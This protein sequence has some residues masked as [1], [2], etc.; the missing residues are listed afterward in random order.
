M[1]PSSSLL[2]S[3]VIPSERSDAPFAFRA[4]VRNEGSLFPFRGCPTGRFYLWGSCQ[5][6]TGIP[7]SVLRI[8]RSRVRR[9][10]FPAPLTLRVA[11][12][13]ETRVGLL[14]LSSRSSLFS[15]VFSGGRSAGCPTG[16]LYLWG[17]CRNSTGIPALVLRIRRSRVRRF[18]AVSPLSHHSGIP[19]DSY[20][21]D[22]PACTESHCEGL[23]PSGSDEGSAAEGRAAQSSPLDMVQYPHRVLLGWCKLPSHPQVTPVS[24]FPEPRFGTVR[25]TCPIRRLTRT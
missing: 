10:L 5:N 11:H 19:D 13:C 21:A 22:C 18:C 24:H 16:H 2:A 7:T 17:S 9:F 14:P 6:S 8:R 12:P 20:L 1:N 23:P 3:L 25:P 15:T 4:G